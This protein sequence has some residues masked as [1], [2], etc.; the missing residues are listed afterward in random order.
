MDYANSFRKVFTCA[1]TGT[2]YSGWF[3]ISK[4]NEL[5][6]WLTFSETGTAD[7][8]TID[9]TLE[10]YV[11]YVT[12]T[13]TTVLTHTQATE[14]ESRSENEKSLLRNNSANVK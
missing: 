9:V 12:P 1:A 11:P 5:Y 2:Q 13:A 4:Y 3:D 8:E 6:S 14:G 7:A 10:R